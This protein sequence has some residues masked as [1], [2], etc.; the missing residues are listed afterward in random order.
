MKAVH[1]VTTLLG[2]THQSSSPHLEHQLGVEGGVGKRLVVSR[3]KL[4]CC[5][6]EIC[7]ESLGWKQFSYV[8]SIPP[9]PLVPAKTKV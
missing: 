4:V 2:K 1:R 6:V 5:S 3:L 9:N 7:L 8:P